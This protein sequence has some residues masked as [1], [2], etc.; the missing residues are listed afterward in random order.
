MTTLHSPATPAKTQ[1]VWLLIDSSSVGGAERHVANLAAALR[2]RGIAAEIVLYQAHGRNPWIDQIE[3]A[4][5]QYRVLDGSPRGLLAAL[6]CDRPGLV[7]T[8][9]YKAGILGRFAACITGVPVVATFHAGERSGWPVGAYEWLDDWTAIL[10]GRIAVSEPVRARLPFGAEV[11]PSFLRV[12]P[13]PNLGPLPLSVGFVGRLSEEKGPDLFCRLA[14]AAPPGLAWH[15]F[16]DGPLRGDLEA[17]HAGRVTF[18]G[19][20]TDVSV[21]W[22]RIG[23]LC[24]PSRFEGVPLAALEAMANGV[25][26]LA[27]RVGGLPGMIDDGV[28]G[29]LFDRDDLAGG[30]AALRRWRDLDAVGSRRMRLAAWARIRDRFSEE[31]LLPKILAVYARRGWK[32]PTL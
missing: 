22:A 4:G 14:E 25:P 18:H 10:G 16:G 30:L 17:R 2:G 6:R 1:P 15:V 29:F 31:R 26:A 32:D 21:I 9:G 5:L 13:E 11:I 19:V 20:V 7:H 28:Q 3:G 12:P 23:L 24:M 27:S 8:H